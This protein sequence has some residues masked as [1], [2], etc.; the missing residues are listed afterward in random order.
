MHAFIRHSAAS[1]ARRPRMLTFCPTC[2]NVLS[3]ERETD[4][5]ARLRAEISTSPS[6]CFGSG[7][8]RLRCASCPYAYEVTNGVKQRVEHAKKTLDDVLGGEEAWK[9]VD[10]TSET[11]PKCAYDSAYFMQI[12]I[13]SADEPT[14]TFYKC[15]RAE[16]G[17]QWREG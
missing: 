13:R 11:C 6:R 4:D 10:K 3:L 1:A 7:G 16:C 14:S 15:C 17:H 2:G 9:N 12:Q 8:V 5:D